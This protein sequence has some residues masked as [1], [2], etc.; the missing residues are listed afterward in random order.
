[1]LFMY[2][3]AGMEGMFVEIATPGRRGAQAP[4]R[5]A[6]DIQ[7]LVGVAAKCGFSIEG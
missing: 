5:T 6:A 3:P 7:A 4:P 2:S 1:M